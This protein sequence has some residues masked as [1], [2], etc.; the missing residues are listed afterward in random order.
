MSA[1]RAVAQLRRPVNL[2]VT[3]PPGSGKTTV[4]ERV[5]ASLQRGVATGFFTREVREGE[6]VESEKLGVTSEFA[7]LGMDF[8]MRK[9][10]DRCTT[11]GISKGN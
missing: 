3:G 2:L 6:E 7:R 10:A 9:I 4:V 11:S 1:R 5:V 8:R